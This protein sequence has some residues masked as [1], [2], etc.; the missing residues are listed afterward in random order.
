M[1]LVILAT[2]PGYQLATVTQI[3]TLAKE[4]LSALTILIV[5]AMVHLLASTTPTVSLYARA[6]THMPR[7]IV[8]EIHCPTVAD[9]MQLVTVGLTVT[10]GQVAVADQASWTGR[11]QVDVSDMQ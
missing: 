10:A 3:T 7:M 2:P 9:L 1:G 4:K 8:A 6:I 5:T 11:H